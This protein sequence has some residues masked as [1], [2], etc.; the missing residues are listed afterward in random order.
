MSSSLS[1]TD[2]CHAVMFHIS[3]GAASLML[4]GVRPCDTGPGT[5][6][7]RGAVGGRSPGTAG[8]SA[9]F[10]EPRKGKRVQVVTLRERNPGEKM[11]LAAAR[12]TFLMLFS[13]L[14]I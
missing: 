6:T 4:M 3:G 12:T 13:A 9:L 10:H 5:G 8:T 1:V 7:W 2:V 11:H 14:K